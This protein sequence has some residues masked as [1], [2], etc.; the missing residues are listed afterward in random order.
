MPIQFFNMERWYFYAMALVAAFLLFFPFYMETIR[1]PVG[2]S[3][4][5]ITELEYIDNYDTELWRS[6]NEWISF[7]CD[8]CIN[9]TA[10]NNRTGNIT[11]PDYPNGTCNCGVSLKLKF[12]VDN[13]E[14]YNNLACQIYL[15]SILIK[16]VEEDIQK[17]NEYNI[18][19]GISEGAR[20][21][22]DN[23]IK[24]CCNG[25]CTDRVLYRICA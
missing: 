23:V 7:S 3:D 13:M 19:I 14:T 18:L 25:E 6:Y 9:G 24:V 10:N 17:D 16:T 4:I 20:K 2:Y 22:S 1:M 21:D 11:C 12:I 15:N 5:N 8:L